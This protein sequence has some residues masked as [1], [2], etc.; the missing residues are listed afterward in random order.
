MNNLSPGGARENR[1]S[2]S[3]STN[4]RDMNLDG[5]LCLRALATGTDPVSGQALGG[6]MREQ[7]LRIQ[8]G[9]SETRMT[10]NLRGKPAIV[11]TG[12]ADAILPP[13]HAS[14]AYVA[15]NRL[16]EPVSQLRYYEITNAH[17]LDVLN[18]IAGFDARYVPLHVYYLQSLNLMWEHLKHGKGLPPSQVVRTTPRATTDGKVEP[19]RAANVPPISQAIGGPNGLISIGMDNTLRIPE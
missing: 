19:L 12:R 14:R 17:H 9:I 18:G 11:V 13:N 1:I 2:I 15:M 7:H 10:A 5:A 6:A 16:V 3:P 8:Q 4:R